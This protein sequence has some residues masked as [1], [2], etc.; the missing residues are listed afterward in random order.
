MGTN[1]ERFKVDYMQEF[2]AFA[3]PLFVK[4]QEVQVFDRV[5]QF[6]YTY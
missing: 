6:Q 5:D 2:F 1:Q 4:T 3:Q